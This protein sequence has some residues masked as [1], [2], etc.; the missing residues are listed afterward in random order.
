M[1]GSRS[2][3][4]PGV[5]VNRFER[6]S[7]RARRANEDLIGHCSDSYWVI[8]GATPLYPSRA[9]SGSS[10]A[11]RL[12]KHIDRR[13]RQHLCNGGPNLLS[14]AESVSRDVAS[15]LRRRKPKRQSQLPSAACGLVSLH[16]D[17]IDYLVLGDVAIVVQTGRRFVS[18]TDPSVERFDRK[19]ARELGREVGKG[20]KFRSARKGVEEMLRAHRDLMNQEG[21]YW[22]LGASPD[23]ASHAEHG[24]IPLDGGWAKV[25]LASDGFARAVKLFQIYKG[26]RQL[27]SALEHRTLRNVVDEI[28]E[29]ERGDPEALEF[30]RLSRSDDASALFIHYESEDS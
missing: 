27:F 8:D 11:Q 17:R 12:V 13:F 9:K 20:A 3:E 1:P 19:V 29:V 14:A 23:A 15:H 16:P 24:S 10:D 2:T 6:T 21:G 4:Q 30:P 22:V 5:V 25:L 18:L 26:W 28:R 7:V